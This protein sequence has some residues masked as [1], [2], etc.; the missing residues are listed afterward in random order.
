[1]ISQPFCSATRS[2]AVRAARPVWNC[3]NVVAR[4]LHL[5]GNMLQVQQLGWSGKLAE[6][7][8]GPRSGKGRVWKGTG[9]GPGLET[10]LRRVSVLGVS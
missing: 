10:D 3:H 8:S 7:G 4:Q 1:M 9:K 2:R 5:R 6:S